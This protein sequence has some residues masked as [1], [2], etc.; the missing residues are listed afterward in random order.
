[1]EDSNEKFR[2]IMLVIMCLKIS[3]SDLESLNEEINEK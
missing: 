3:K 2:L 1:M